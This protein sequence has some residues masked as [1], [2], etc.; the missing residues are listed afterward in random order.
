MVS[1]KSVVFRKCSFS[2]TLQEGDTTYTRA[3]TAAQVTW[4]PLQK[5]Q[6]APRGNLAGSLFL[7][8]LG[9]TSGPGHSGEKLGDGSGWT[10]AQGSRPTGTCHLPQSGLRRPGRSSSPGPLVPRPRPKAAWLPRTAL[11]EV[12]GFP[13]TANTTLSPGP[14]TCLGRGCS[15]P[16][17][18]S[19]PRSPRSLRTPSPT[20]AQTCRDSGVSPTPV[21]A[22]P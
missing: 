11:N 8:L 20:S 18:W 6:S 1:R 15:P 13:H 22:S 16:G 9:D 4:H 19:W 2:F 7:F 21:Q 17:P 10:K 3:F 12:P 5:D 14:R